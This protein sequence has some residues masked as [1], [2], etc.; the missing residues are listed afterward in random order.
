MR[1]GKL[2]LEYILDNIM[3]FTMLRNDLYLGSVSYLE[4]K[5]EEC[6]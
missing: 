1:I 6:S 2:K 3:G 5:Y 4:D